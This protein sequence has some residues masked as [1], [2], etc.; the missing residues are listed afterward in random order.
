M[1]KQIITT[2]I[3]LIISL[4]VLGMASY[5][6]FSNNTVVAA[7]GMTVSVE[8]PINIMA[9]LN[10]P[11]ATANP[12]DPLTVTTLDGYRNYFQFGSITDSGGTGQINEFDMLVPVSSADGINFLYLPF[13]F[14]NEDGCPKN[15][16]T[17][18]DYQL[19]PQDINKGYIID[20]PLYLLTTTPLDLN[21]YV[22]FIDI[23]P[24]GVEIDRPEIAGAVRAT[25]LIKENGVYRSLVIAKDSKAQ[26]LVSNTYPAKT[27]YPMRYNGMTAVEATDDSAVYES[28][29]YA[30]SVPE[31]NSFTLRSSAMADGIATYYVT[32]IRLRIWVEG[33]DAAAIFNNAGAYFTVSMA[34]A[35]D[36]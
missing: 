12:D 28:S 34:L 19:V 27:Y 17:V 3:F 5:A 8:L 23:S 20:I 21:V 18:S 24:A 32:E 10:P 25:V 14:V 1:R 9:S 35:V 4:S 22:S 30:P 26:A 11:A 33:S 29:A 6:W 31:G 7:S 2:L 36:G 16:V 13:R 15:D